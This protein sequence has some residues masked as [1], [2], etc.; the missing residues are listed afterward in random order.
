MAKHIYVIAGH[1]AGDSG[2]VG[3]GYKEAELVRVLAQ[4]IADLGGEYVRLHPFKDNAYASNAISKLSIPKSWAIVELH[5]D[6]A[7]A[8]AKGGHVIIK[9]NYK[10]NAY[11][12]ALAKLMVEFFPGRSEKIVNRGD[13]ANANRAAAR[14]YDYR[15][16]ENGFITNK[17]DVATFNANVDALARGYLKAFG[18]PVDGA[19][20]VKVEQAVEKVQ[21]ATAQ[22]K[23]NALVLN[24]QKW[25]NEEYGAGLSEDGVVGAKTRKALVKA[26][27]KELNAQYRRGLDVDGIWGPKTKAACVN[28]HQGA[29]GDITRVMQLALICEGYSKGG[30]DGVFGSG[31]LS[32]LKRF[33]KA[34][35]LTVDGICGRNTWSKLLG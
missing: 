33:Q 12:E 23:G 8:S 29:R 28:V 14:G 21:K 25:L 9:S 30:F 7:S 34:E 15:L 32:D 27:Q 20:A 5:M 22:A 2:A 35:G 31:T 16:V 13:L 24:G 3:N 10:A 6:S 17:G 4:R 11:D 19:P 26:L 1:G 18:I